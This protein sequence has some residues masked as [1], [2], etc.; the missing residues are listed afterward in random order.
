M[1][2]IPAIDLATEDSVNQQSAPSE[3]V[4]EEYKELAKF[5]KWKRV[6]K[7]VNYLNATIST[8]VSWDLIM[9]QSC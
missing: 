6:N 4:S 2:S 5:Y 7:N 3:D 8:K 1:I 9:D